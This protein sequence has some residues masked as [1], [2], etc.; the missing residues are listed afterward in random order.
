MTSNIISCNLNI[1]D[2]HKKM[3]INVSHELKHINEP[4]P[5]LEPKK[6]W[7]SGLDL[8]KTSS[9]HLYDDC[10]NKIGKGYLI[11]TNYNDANTVFKRIG[12]FYLDFGT[13]GRLDIPINFNNTDPESGELFF[14]NKFKASYIIFVSET[15][16]VEPNPFFGNK[17]L[18]ELKNNDYKCNLDIKQIS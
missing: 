11:L 12:T 2:L 15:N 13:N 3:Q 17:Y 8:V 14:S 5:H 4:L 7:R 16:T 9:C 1:H 6:L 18:I 10:E